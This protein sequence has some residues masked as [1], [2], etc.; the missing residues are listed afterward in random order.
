MKNQEEID[1]HERSFTTTKKISESI[2]EI[3]R[4]A[5]FVDSYS[6]RSRD[7]FNESEKAED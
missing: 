1:R 7:R 4:K 2:E 5:I 3:E 6:G